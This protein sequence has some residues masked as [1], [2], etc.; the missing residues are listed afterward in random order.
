MARLGATYPDFGHRLVEAWDAL[1]ARDR[2]ILGQL[3]TDG[4]TRTADKRAL[5]VHVLIETLGAL[6]DVWEIAGLPGVE[7]ID[8]GLMDFVSDHHGAIPGAA[9]KSPG[10]FEHPLIVRAKC[11]IATA[12]LARGI[13][14]T[15]NVTTELKDIDFIEDRKRVV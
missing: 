4:P 5:P 7:S 10:Q 15:H 2:G 6:H 8:F 9:M 13:V 1:S 3:A 14:P 12:A 11:E